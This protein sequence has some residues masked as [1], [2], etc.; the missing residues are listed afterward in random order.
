MFFSPSFFFKAGIQLDESVLEAVLEM[1]ENNVEQ[2]KTYLELTG[3]EPAHFV[4]IEQLAGDGA[5]VP[6]VCSDKIL[7]KLKKKFD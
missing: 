2:A 6:K 5:R 3:Q 1:C 7:K 4:P